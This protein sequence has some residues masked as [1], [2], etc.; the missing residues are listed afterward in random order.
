MGRELGRISG[1]LLASNLLRNGVD[2]AFETNLLYL[3]VTNGRIGVNTS[4]VTRT[5]LVNGT[6]NVTG[7]IQ[8][9]EQADVANL[10]FLNNEIS[11]LA[12]KIYLQPNQDTDPTITTTRIGTANLRISDKLIE[13]ITLDSDINLTPNG[14]GLLN[15]TTNKVNVDGWL[16]STGNITWA[17]DVTL[18]TGADDNVEFA[19]DINSNIIPDDNN[20]WDLG[21]PSQRWNT[22]RAKT[23]TATTGTVDNISVIQTLLSKN[24]T[25]FTGATTLVG[26]S[27]LDHTTFNAT[28]PN[29]LI[30][31]GSRSLGINGTAWNNLNVVNA[32]FAGTFGITNLI[33]SG[34]VDVANIKINNNELSATTTNA[35]LNFV[36]LDA[37]G[38][39]IENRLKFKDNEISNVWASPTTDAQKSIYLTPNGSGDVVINTT[40]ALVLP[41]GNITTRNLSN[42]AELR[43]NTNSNLVEGYVPNGRFNLNNLYDGNRNTYI[44]P[45]LTP[46]A[47]DDLL[48][49]GING[50]VKA[51]ISPTKLFS[52]T[53]FVDNVS[54]SGN[55]LSNRV[56]TNDLTLA[57]NGAG[58]LDVNSL[59]FKDSNIINNTSLPLSLVSTG[60][61]YVKFGGTAA[62][63]FPSGD[64]AQRPATPEQGTTRYNTEEGYL[65]IWTGT[66]WIPTVGT[67]LAISE[68]EVRGI[69]DEWTLILG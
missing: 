43:Y 46:G 6:T 35:D 68:E 5:F 28:I 9:D 1:P 39:I 66:A 20:T 56:S 61:G 52:N 51:T 30:P 8:V 3:D 40:K 55:T 7:S 57:P 38:V 14:T 27:P 69:L 24:T 25:S 34:Y 58:Y 23:T 67:T 13:N 11:N 59:L 15:V 18:G 53:M 48:R 10:T 64:N 19:A 54:I 29:T 37:G 47:S 49:F 62:V 2:L 21:S 12:N 41:L 42:V 45:E 17:G 31:S 44:T 65:E 32:N 22:V 26:D 36:G 60:T 50:T 63:V 4:T 16:H 33:G